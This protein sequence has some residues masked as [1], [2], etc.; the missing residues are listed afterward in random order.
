MEVVVGG[1]EAEQTLVFVAFRIL[2]GAKF[3]AEQ[4]G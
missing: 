2:L 1:T 3:E 4:L